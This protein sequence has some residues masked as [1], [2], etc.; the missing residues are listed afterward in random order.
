MCYG[1]DSDQLFASAFDFFILFFF[2]KVVNSRSKILLDSVGPFSLGAKFEAC[3]FQNR[4][5]CHSPQ[6]HL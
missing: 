6:I 4:R 2:P 3:S 5:K 1:V